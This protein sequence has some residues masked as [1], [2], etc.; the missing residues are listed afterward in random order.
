MLSDTEYEDAAHALM[1]HLE[2][3]IENKAP[4]IDFESENEILTLEFPDRS[5]IIINKQRPLKEIWVAARSGGYHYHYDDRR[6]AWLREGGG[7][8]IND[9]E[10]FASDQLKAPVILT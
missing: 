8:L 7:E 9:I 1:V 5:R 2:Q 10:R 3:L 6:Q 4:L